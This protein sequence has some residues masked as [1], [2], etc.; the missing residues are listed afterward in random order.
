MHTKRVVVVGTGDLLQKEVTSLL[1]KHF[2]LTNII[3]NESLYIH[4][5]APVSNNFL[6]HHGDVLVDLTHNK[7]LKRQLEHEMPIVSPYMYQGIHSTPGRKLAWK[8]HLM[9]SSARP[10]LNTPHIIYIK[11]PGVE[12]D[13]LMSQYKKTLLPVV[14]HGEGVYP[15]TPI[16]SFHEFCDELNGVLG[17]DGYAYI[18]HYIPGDLVHLIS[19]RDF[20]DEPIYTSPLISKGKTG[21]YSSVKHLTHEK[22]KKIEHH[23]KNL[24]HELGLGPLSKFDIVIGNKSVHLVDIDANPSL[25]KNDVVESS[26]KTVGA[27]MGEFWKQVVENARREFKSRK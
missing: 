1:S 24:H 2:A 23:V 27:N 25:R 9:E 19:I 5:G 10:D 16:Y 3:L 11:S 26:L 17:R 21:E 12:D 6:I 13:F 20:R 15:R 7:E 14:I 4:Q 22:R 18:E 8:K